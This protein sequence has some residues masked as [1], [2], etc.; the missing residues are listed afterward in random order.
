MLGWLAAEELAPRLADYD[1]CILPSNF[2]GC[3]LALLEAMAA[4]LPLVTTAVGGNPWV[5]KDKKHG[6]VIAP[7]RPK[8]LARTTNWACD[9]PGEMN[10][11]GRWAHK[12]ALKRYHWGR[13]VGDY[14]RLFERVRTAR[15]DVA[16]ERR[17]G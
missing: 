9:H 6:L 8:L 10:L 12:K 5:V 16:G 1:L 13:V 17:A 11:M 14:M 7:A 15:A 3:S 4:G 2:E